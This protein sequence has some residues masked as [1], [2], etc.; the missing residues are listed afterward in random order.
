MKKLLL[1]IITFNISGCSNELNN[2][3]SKNNIDQQLDNNFI[4]VNNISKIKIDSFKIKDFGFKDKFDH[5]DND[6]DEYDSFNGLDK[7]DLKYEKEWNYSFKPNLKINDVL[8]NGKSILKNSSYE[9]KPD[10]TKDKNI[11]LTLKG[12]FKTWKPIRMKDMGFTYETCLLQQSIVSNRPLVKVLINDSII[13]NPVSVS[14][15]E[16]KVSI[17][18]KYIPDFYLKGLHKLTFEARKYYTE[19]LIKVGSPEPIN[20]SLAPVITK[21]DILKDKKG[22]PQNIKLTGK[23]FMMY[24]RFSYSTINDIHAFG[25]QTNIL[26]D[27]S[28]ETVVHIPEPEKFNVSKKNSIMYATPFGLAIKDF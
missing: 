16:I 27:G 6:E 10:F 3:I 22:K 11:Q 23:N 15:D 18:T 21:I 4:Y 17:N 28:Y 14:D 5:E 1:L 26:D 9:L 24:Y 12:S 2:I 25:H 19:T 8:Y 20:N 13:L 7:E